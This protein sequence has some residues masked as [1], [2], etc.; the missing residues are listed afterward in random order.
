M[1]WIL[2][3]LSRGVTGDW[4]KEKACQE[5]DCEELDEEEESGALVP[6]DPFER[7]ADVEAGEDGKLV[8]QDC[9]KFVFFDAAFLDLI[10]RHFSLQVLD[11]SSRPL[12]KQDLDQAG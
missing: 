3:A 5:H 6:F 8:H 7:L 2:L 11:V 9:A 1:L 4:Q 10:N 12:Q